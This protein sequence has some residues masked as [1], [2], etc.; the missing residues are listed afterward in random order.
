MLAWRHAR[1]RDLHARGA[2]ASR[3]KREAYF[4]KHEAIAR[5]QLKNRRSTY[6]WVNP[7]PCRKASTQQRPRFAFPSG[8]RLD[9]L[10]FSRPS[11]F[12]RACFR[13]EW[14]DGGN[15]C[16]LEIA[17]IVRRHG[18][19]IFEGCCRDHEIRTTTANSR[20]ELSPAPRCR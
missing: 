1:A 12:S 3:S 10:L 20:T 16:R 9:D 14:V 7:L 11:H 19:S 5:A 8:S 2:R 18:Q 13:A 17:G 15:T 6:E 4:D